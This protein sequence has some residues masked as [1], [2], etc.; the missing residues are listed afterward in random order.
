MRLIDADALKAYFEEKKGLRL[1]NGETYY[2]EITL[3]A[4]DIFLHAIDSAPTIEAEPVKHDKWRGKIKV[5]FDIIFVVI[6]YCVFFVCGLKLAMFFGKWW[7]MPLIMLFT[8]K[9]S[10]KTDGEKRD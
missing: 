1:P 8:P 2:S 5:D 10:K 6:M 4:I 3:R 7:L 9:Y